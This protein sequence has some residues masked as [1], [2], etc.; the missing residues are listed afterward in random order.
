LRHGRADRAILSLSASRHGVVTRADLIRAG[1]SAEGIK[2]RIRSRLLRPVHRGVY[3]VGRHATA[4]SRAMA[5]ARACG[6]C[7]AVSHQGAAG[8]RGILRAADRARRVDI[9]LAVGDRRR[10]GI[11]IHHHDLPADE[12]T[13]LNGIPVTTAARTLLDI[14]GELSTRALEQ[15]LIEAFARR[16][17]D[18]AELMKL[19]ARHP[20][21]AGNA[22]LRAVLG[23]DGSS[24]VRSE[25]EARFGSLVRD[26]GLPEP[27]SNVEVGGVEVDF[28]W[29]DERLIVEVDG[30]AF[31]STAERFEVDRRRDR[32]LIAAG[33]R[34]IRVTWRQIR[35][36]PMAVAVHVSRALEGS[37]D[38][39]A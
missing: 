26:A 3:I 20:R 33:Y 2:R 39:D 16:L 22:R 10:P 15:A 6:E 38:A 9:T 23:A 5:A 8:L 28:L 14:A 25:A 13:T 30:F 32:A 24:L 29:R 27:V 17:T 7:A 35:D 21:H 34:V 36:E 4:Q 11:R 31:H 19:L 1:V 12:V 37:A 18:S